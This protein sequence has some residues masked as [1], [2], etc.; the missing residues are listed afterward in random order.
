MMLNPILFCEFNPFT[1]KLITDKELLV[2]AQFIFY[3][4]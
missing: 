1:F 2:I 4:P 3:M